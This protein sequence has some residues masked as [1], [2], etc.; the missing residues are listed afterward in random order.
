[1]SI[2]DQ[3][4]A[5]FKH[6]RW[7]PGATNKEKTQCLALAY[8]NARDVMKRLDDVVGSENWQ[9]RYPFE[10]CCEIGIRA[11]AFDPGDDSL[12]DQWIWK[13]NGAG[14]SDIEGEKGQ[15]SDAFKRAA[16]VWGIG[17][18]LYYLPAEWVAYDKFKKKIVNPP[19]LPAWAQY[20]EE[21]SDE[22]SSK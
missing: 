17:R 22:T 4:M 15:Y 5:P 7:M 18:Y 16:A 8:I 2:H 1:M 14:Q 21:V 13:A 3:L 12:V 6:L 20:R 11:T 10:G 9:V 19:A